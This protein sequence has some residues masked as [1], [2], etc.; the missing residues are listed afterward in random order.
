MAVEFLKN[1]GFECCLL[2][3][4]VIAKTTRIKAASF[5]EDDGIVVGTNV[6]T[7]TARTDAPLNSDHS[8][9]NCYFDWEGFHGLIVTALAAADP[10]IA[11]E[12]F[13]YKSTEHVVELDV[14]RNCERI[15]FKSD[16]ETSRA[17]K[18]LKIFQWPVT[19]KTRVNRHSAKPIVTYMEWKLGI[20]SYAATYKGTAEV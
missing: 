5:D 17:L 8:N 15:A 11:L 16:G 2:T 19:L 14:W 12:C 4:D 13:Q 20:C 6:I 9:R 3:P 18:A 7:I 10:P 1:V